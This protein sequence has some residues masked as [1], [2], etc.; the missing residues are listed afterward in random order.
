VLDKALE[1]AQLEAMWQMESRKGL[2]AGTS[3]SNMEQMMANRLTP[4]ADDPMGA[5]KQKLAFLQEKG[6]FDIQLARELKRSKLTYD[7]F[8]DTDT[9][10]KMFSDYQKRLMNITT[11]APAAGKQNKPVT[12]TG[13]ITAESLRNRLNPQKPAQ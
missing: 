9:F 6:K 4:S 7:Q 12:Q 8:E 11:G 1:L 3:V 10:D 2:G 13:P 5:Y